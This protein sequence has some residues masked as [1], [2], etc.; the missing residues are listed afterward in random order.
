MIRGTEKSTRYQKRT[1]AALPLPRSV[2]VSS[3]TFHLVHHGRGRRAKSGARGD[4]VPDGHFDASVR[5]VP[6][7]EALRVHQAR[8]AED[9]GGDHCRR[10]QAEGEGPGEPCDWSPY[11]GYACLPPVIGPRLP[12]TT[13]SSRVGAHNSGR[14]G[15]PA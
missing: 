7:Q 1:H 4:A 8:R 2:A 3:R 15:M 6:L 5:G 12:L 14:G 13:T 11:Q 9:P 10:P